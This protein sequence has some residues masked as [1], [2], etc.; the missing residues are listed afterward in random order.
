MQ[1][2]KNEI[3]GD[4]LITKPQSD[5][6]RNNWDLVFGKAKEMIQQLEAEEHSCYCCGGFGWDILAAETDMNRSCDC[7]DGTGVAA[8]D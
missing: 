1:K 3:T 5:L 2:Q 4:T 6:Y 7:C 8:D